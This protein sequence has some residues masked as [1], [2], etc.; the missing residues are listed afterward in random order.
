VTPPGD[1]LVEPSGKRLPRLELTEL[2]TQRLHLI[3][4]GVERSCAAWAARPAA[5]ARS[6]SIAA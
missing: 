4:I 5:Q 1:E 2:L 6:S 3:F